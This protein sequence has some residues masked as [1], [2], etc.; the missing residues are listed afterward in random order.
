MEKFKLG[1]QF[2]FKIDDLIV[3]CKQS[4]S[5]DLSNE[6]VI[7]RNDCTGDWGVRLPGGD[8]SASMQFEADLDFAANGI[9]KLSWYEL[10]PKLGNLVEVIF[11]DE[12]GGEKYMIFDATLDNLSLNASRNEGIT[13]SG[14]LNLSGEP[15]IITATT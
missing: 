1:K 2:T 7:I 6:G 5:L 13:F 3:T 10:I 4:A 15:S 14:T 8:K 12:T 9:T 11:G